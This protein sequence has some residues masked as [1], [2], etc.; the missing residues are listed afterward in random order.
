MFHAVQ[1]FPIIIF[2]LFTNSLWD[3]FIDVPNSGKKY[4]YLDIQNFYM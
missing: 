4:I 2:G 1:N 3:H